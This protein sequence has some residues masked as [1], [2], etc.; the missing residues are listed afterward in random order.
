MVRTVL[1]GD[2]GPILNF[3]YTERVDVLEGAFGE[4]LIPAEVRSELESYGVGLGSNGRMRE[5]G[6]SRNGWVRDLS[7]L[8]AGRRR[9]GDFRDRDTKVCF[10]WR[11][12]QG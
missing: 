6:L 8:Q 5:V 9:G 7:G 1:V 10:D 11:R 3:V 4:I 2:T 12:G